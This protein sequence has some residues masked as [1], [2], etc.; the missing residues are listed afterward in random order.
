MTYERP[1]GT[2]GRGVDCFNLRFL[3]EIHCGANAVC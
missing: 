1:T 3:R 2:G